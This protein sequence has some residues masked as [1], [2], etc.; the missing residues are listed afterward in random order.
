MIQIFTLTRVKNSMEALLPF[1]II[2]FSGLFLSE[3]FQRVHLPWVIALIVSGFLVGPAGVGIIE[4][5]QTLEFLAS[6]GLI[7]VMFMAGIETDFFNKSRQSHFGKA[8]VLA[9][10]GGSLSWLFGYILAGALGLPF[11]AAVLLGIIFISSSV[12]VAF[13]I[14]EGSGIIDKG[15]GKTI[16]STMIIQDFLSLFVF[17]IFSRIV[18]PDKGLNVLVV[19]VILIASFFVLRK[20]IP[21]IRGYFVKEFHTDEQ[22]IFEQELRAVLVLLVGI[23]AFFALLGIHEILAAFLAGMILTDLISHRDIKKNIHA[24]GYGIFIPIFFASIGITTQINK[25]NFQ[26]PNV[27]FLLTS[28]VVGTLFIRYIALYIG[29]RTVHLSHAQ[30]KVVGSSMLPQLSTTLALGFAGR[31]MGLFDET[32]VTALVLMSIFSILVTPI[33]LRRSLRGLSQ[34]K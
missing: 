28:V 19:Y 31:Q 21:M 22:D 32:L 5:S 30:A 27:W 24:L 18:S 10:I 1:F 29:S 6:L 11:L 23:V 20:G 33:L 2:L 15:L 17:S 4:S 13:P 26:E 16:L 25:I 3:F 8:F 34:S 7:F 14:L 9:L 12:A